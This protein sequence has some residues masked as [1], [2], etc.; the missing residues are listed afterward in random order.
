[1]TA[2]PVTINP[3]IVQDYPKGHVSLEEVG[4]NTG[5][6]PNPVI[7][8]STSTSEAAHQYRF[9]F[10][11]RPALP[12]L[13]GAREIEFG[14]GGADRRFGQTQLAAHDVGA[15]DHRHAFVIGDAAG[16]AFAAKAA[17]GGDDEPLGRDVFER[18]ADQLRRP[19][20]AGST[21]VLQ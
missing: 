21:I 11:C 3:A 13:A 8:A 16:E 5:R 12:H 9:L 2:T 18:L 20:S 17:I 1:M 14:V 6:H 4:S 7:P 10:H 15:F 19:F